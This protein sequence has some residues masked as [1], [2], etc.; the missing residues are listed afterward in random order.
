MS[1]KLDNLHPDFRPLAVELLASCVEAGIP[2]AILDTLRTP[3]EQLVLI[4]RN[5]SWT[6][7]SKHLVGKAIDIAPWEEF[8]RHGPDKFQWDAN[9]P[10]WQKIGRIG[11]RLELIWGGDWTKKDMGH[12]ELKED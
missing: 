5:R 3:Q 1:R 4:Q 2:V 10:V 9:D 12:F 8:N 11:K 7:K 6:T